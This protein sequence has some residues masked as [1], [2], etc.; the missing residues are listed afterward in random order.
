MDNIN[1]Q[2]EC[3][4]NINEYVESLIKEVKDKLN[5]NV[6]RYG[7][8]RISFYYKTKNNLFELINIIKNKFNIIKRQDVFNIF[9]YISC[10]KNKYNVLI[11]RD[12]INTV[13]ELIMFYNINLD[14]K[15]K[16]VFINDEIFVIYKRKVDVYENYEVLNQSLLYDVKNNYNDFYEYFKG[17]NNLI[18]Q[19]L[20]RLYEN[21]IENKEYY[22]KEQI[23]E[24]VDHIKD[25]LSDL[26][27]KQERM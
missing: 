16:L 7:K 13:L 14:D 5:I 10:F 24:K 12:E 25:E 2:K 26:Y 3:F 1:K 17:Q 22:N 4:D 6:C 20:Y 9:S 15:F 8:A 23:K 11:E 19:Y 21:L 18:S 27:F